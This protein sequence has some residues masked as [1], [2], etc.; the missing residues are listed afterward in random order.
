MAINRGQRWFHSTGLSMGYA[1]VGSR[2]IA[3]CTSDIEE[4]YSDSH[5][6]CFQGPVT[7][8]DLTTR[9]KLDRPVVRV[10]QRHP[11]NQLP[12]ARDIIA[13]NDGL[14]DSLN[15]TD[16]NLGLLKLTK[17]RLDADA[18]DKSEAALLDSKVVRMRRR[19][20]N[21]RWVVGDQIKCQIPGL[22]DWC[23][24]VANKYSFIYLYI[25]QNSHCLT[26]LEV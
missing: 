11:G 2:F 21:H 18:R 25:Q 17:L 13:G 19:L 14:L 9:E 6:L 1:L 7:Y 16:R 4:P 5:C 24:Y 8:S 20:A 10:F 22:N 26:I 15:A 3:T 12:E 23:E